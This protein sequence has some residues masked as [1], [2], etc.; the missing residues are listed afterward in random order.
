MMSGCSHN[1]LGGVRKGV[2]KIVRHNLRLVVSPQGERQPVFYPEQSVIFDLTLHNDGAA[3]IETPSLDG[4]R[5]TPNYRVFDSSGQM[6]IDVTAADLFAQFDSEMGEPE[7]EEFAMEDLAPGA[8]AETWFDLWSFTAPLPK[9]RYELQA[10]HMIAA[11]SD[12]FVESNR[13]AFEIVEADVDQIAAGYENGLHEASVIAWLVKGAAANERELLARLSVEGNHGAAQRSGRWIG[14]TPQGSRLSVSDKPP[15][16]QGSAY[17]WLAVSSSTAEGSAVEMIQ[18]LRATPEWQSEIVRL[19][20]RDLLP[21]PRFPDRGLPTFLATGV[22][23]SGGAVLTGI[24]FN[25][26]LAEAVPWTAPLSRRATRSACAFTASGPIIVLIASEDEGVTRLSRLRVD[27]TGELAAGEQEVHTSSNRL[28]GLAAEMRAAATPGFVALESSRTQPDRLTLVR[29]PLE[30]D[31]EV[32]EL[33]EVQGWPTSEGRPVTPQQLHLEI[34]LDGTPFI[35]LLDERGAYFFG[36]L[37]GAP[38][39]RAM[40][41]DTGRFKLPHIAALTEVTAFSAF[42]ERGYLAHPGVR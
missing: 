3:Q 12:T 20:V 36:S 24:E 19:P 37:D 38:L 27:S 13:L 35:A 39:L 30:G 7:P 11:D 4:N 2:T 10:R 40:P 25:P 21:T 14:K 26:E 15:G 42:T 41:K 5:P 31:A 22:G 29:V 34:G 18:L 8:T 6:V 23:V 16:V 32:R 9:G 17:S 28:L 1:R 33:G